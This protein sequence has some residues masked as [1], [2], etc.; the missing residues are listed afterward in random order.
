[1]S[2]V[3]RAWVD[4]C[5]GEARALVTLDDRP[6]RLLV[7]REGDALP[8]IGQRFGARVEAVSGRLGLARLDLGGAPATLK[9]RSGA[10]PSVGERL[11]VEVVVEPTRGKPAGV[12][13]LPGDGPRDLGA[14]GPAPGFEAQ[15][16]ALGLT[17]WETGADAADRID[18]AQADALAREHLVAPDLTLCVEPT[19]ALTAVDVDLA[20][21]GAPVSVGHANAMALREAARL[22]RL[23]ALGG[24][25]AIDLVG[26][27]KDRDR[28]VAV[29]RDAFAADG[30][31]VHIAPPSR[32]GVLELAKP[33]GRQP[34]HEQLL[35]AD[36]RASPRTAAQML[37]RALERQ[38]RFA[39]GVLLVARCAPEV[40]AEAAP[41]VRRLGPRFA[42]HGEAG[43]SRE[44]CD[45][46][47]R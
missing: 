32:F 23:K 7:V 43:R 40:A 14:L 41:Y 4:Y 3:R 46:I 37:V 39:P 13:R 22:L 19:R 5:P 33:H 24:L 25:I 18:E 31:E 42:V 21:T 44:A 27:P 12:R 30:P 1:M 28:L 20:E 26:F 11:V 16:E 17:T 34:L 9:L 35:D 36:G 15:L 47:E 38:G 29:A 6:E 10:P 2:G 8:R 45:I